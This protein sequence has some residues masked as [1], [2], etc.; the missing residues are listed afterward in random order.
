MAAAEPVAVSDLAAF[1][2]FE[3]EFSGP[4]VE[5]IKQLE[6]LIALEFESP[7]SVVVAIV[8]FPPLTVFVVVVTLFA[9]RSK[10]KNYTR[11]YAWNI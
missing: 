6:F 1:V 11:L 5:L 4:F 7:S 2:G 3:L 10:K 9:A 8:Y